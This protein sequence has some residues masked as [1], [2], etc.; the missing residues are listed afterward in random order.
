MVIKMEK[1]RFSYYLQSLKSLII[2]VLM[3]IGLVSFSCAK[4]DEFLLAEFQTTSNKETQDIRKTIMEEGGVLS[5]VDLLNEQFKTPDQG[6]IKLVFVDVGENQNSEPYT[7]LESNTITIPYQFVLDVKNLFQQVDYGSEIQM[8][9]R[10]PTIDTVLHTILHEVA[11]AMIE[12]YDLPI[13]G[14]EED[15]ADSLATFILAEQFEEGEEIAISAADLFDLERQ[16]AGELDESNYWDEHSLDAQ[17][18]YNT[19]CQVYG[20]NPDKYA[21]LLDK[22]AIDERRQELCIDEYDKLSR[23]WGKLLAPWKK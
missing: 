16:Q 14:K 22:L 9:I 4:A 12:A 21:D 1:F 8:D 5:L 7:D 15:A 2:C 3:F 10:V 6:T 13:V 17:R 18:F 23:S 20:S 19:M 11:H